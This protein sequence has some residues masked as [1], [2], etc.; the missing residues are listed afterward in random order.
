LLAKYSEGL[1]GCTGCIQ[2]EVPQTILDG[3]EQKALDL[4]KEYEQIFGKGNF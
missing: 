3:K 4:A 2:G 1:I